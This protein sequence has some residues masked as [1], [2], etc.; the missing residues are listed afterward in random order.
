MLSG[1]PFSYLRLVR[2][3]VL[4]HHSFSQKYIDWF[5][6]SATL[7]YLK[8]ITLHA[9]KI[10]NMDELGIDSGK[11]LERLPPRCLAYEN[12]KP[13][14][15]KPSVQAVKMLS[16]EG[17]SLL[18]MEQS[19]NIGIPVPVVVLVKWLKDRPD[20]L[21]TEG[22]F[23]KVAAMDEI[24]ELEHQLC[25]KE[26]RAVDAVTNCHLICST[27]KKLLWKCS[28]PPFSMALYKACADT[29]RRVLTSHRQP[30]EEA[31]LRHRHDHARK[32]RNSATGHLPFRIF[33][34]GLCLKRGQSDDH[35]QP[36]H[37]PGALLLQG[38]YWGFCLPGD[39]Q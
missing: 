10:K 2:R 26:Y 23:R 39:R 19:E 21:R 30:R 16:F 9:G 24:V 17:R 36:L 14:L 33:Q 28:E 11:L 37:L 5:N 15:R 20:Q 8:S 25:E 1:L 35:P 34:D 27:L 6:S 22:L 31:G 4:L 38:H 12:I 13:V 7:A 3:I 18:S 29:L 32:G